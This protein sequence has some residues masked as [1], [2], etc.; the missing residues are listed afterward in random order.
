MVPGP[1]ARYAELSTA[2]GWLLCGA[3]L[4]QALS[5]SA[6]LSA[7]VLHT[8]SQSD[9]VGEFAAGILIARVPILAFGVVQARLLP[10]WPG[11]PAPATRRS[12]GRVA[13]PGDDR[14]AGRDHRRRPE[15]HDR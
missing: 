5:Y 10:A 12:P 6:Y 14:A 4:T 2:L 13:A 8:P 3:V 15:L 9:A 11:W 1:E 7:I